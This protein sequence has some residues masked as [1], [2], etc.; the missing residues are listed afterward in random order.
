MN[1]KGL[2]DKES[3]YIGGI[4]MRRGMIRKA[5]TK[6]FNVADIFHVFSTRAVLTS[7]RLRFSSIP[8]YP[9]LVFCSPSWLNTEK[10]YVA[11]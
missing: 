10:S 2:E 7:R 5:A 9:Q 8:P 1:V 3:R 4:D 11:D 6:T